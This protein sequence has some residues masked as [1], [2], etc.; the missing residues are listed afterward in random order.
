MRYISRD[1]NRSNI[2]RPYPD[3]YSDKNGYGYPDIGIFG[4]KYGYEYFFIE[5]KYDF[6][7]ETGY[8]YEYG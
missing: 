2:I 7:F 8:E 5:Y 6:Q 1:A 3:S 4:Y